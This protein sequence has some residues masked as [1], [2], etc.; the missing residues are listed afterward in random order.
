MKPIFLTRQEDDSGLSNFTFF[1]SKFLFLLVLTLLA[2]SI[3]AQQ[4]FERTAPDNY[5]IVFKDK[6]N[7][8]FLL[9]EPGS[10]LSE[11]SLLRRQNQSIPIDYFDLPITPA[12]I[13]S[14][15]AAGAEVLTVSKWFNAVTVRILN[16]TV[17]DRIAKLTFVKKSDENSYSGQSLKSMDLLSVNTNLSSGSMNVSAASVLDYGSSWW[18]TAIHNGHVLH[19]SGYTGSG[20]TMAIIDAGFNQADILPVFNNLWDGNQI[21]GMRDFVEP[22][23]N[24][25]KGASHGMLVLSVIGGNLPGE[26]IGTAPDAD[27]WLLRSEDQGSEYIIEEDNWIAAAEF[28]DSVGAD[29][30][31]SSLGYS[32][33]YDENQDHTYADMDGNTTRIS[34]AADIAAS[35]GLLVISS[36]GNKGDK[37]WHYIT[38][39]ADA[40]SILTVGAIDQNGY[41]AYFSSRGPSS[42]GD[43][44]PDVMAIGESTVMA[45]YNGGITYGNGTSLSAPVISGLAACLWQTNKYASA[46]DVLNSIRESADRSLQ[47][48][49]NY[50]FGIPDFVLANVLLKIKHGVSP[51]SEKAIAYP[52]PF[53][54]EIYLVFHSPVDESIVITLYD[55]TG[56]EIFQRLYTSIQERNYLYLKEEFTALPKGIYVLNIR[57][58]EF[59]EVIKLI[60]L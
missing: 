12:Y 18:Q 44:K 8:P 41:V 1:Y 25:L 5:R 52:N 36:A 33:F 38:A 23:G 31:N 46:M 22:G 14:I 45:D 50:G 28:A 29:I 59:A 48:D 17:Q 43:T 3:P 37:T 39:P 40:D 7:N 27:F 58:G 51:V 19:E 54:S 35:K 4:Q 49:D 13:D 42:D 56:K 24:V 11:K 16:D 55:L 30:I 34:I 57:S 32:T 20:M 21:L 60:K 6:N 9:E 53:S 10:F 2:K 47:P 15:R 26:L